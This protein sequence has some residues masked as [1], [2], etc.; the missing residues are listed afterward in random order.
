MEFTSFEMML[1]SA[2][3]QITEGEIIFSAFQWPTLAVYI[4]KQTHA[5]EACFMYESGIVENVLTPVVPSTLS[6]PMIPPYSV[7][8]GDSIDILCHLQ[9]NWA[10]K[11]LIMAA[12]IDRFGNVNTTVVGDYEKPKIRLPGGGG[13]PSIVALTKKTI[14]MLDEHSPRRFVKDIGFVTDFGYGSGR[15]DRFKKGFPLGTGPHAVISPLG[16][17]KFD[18]KTKEMYLDTVHPG[19]TVDEVKKNTS[20]DL[21]VSPSC[22]EAPPPT[23]EEI[24]ICRKVIREALDM[25]YNIRKEWY[26]QDE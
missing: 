10:D 17:L 2:A 12:M 4:A 24:R 16:I 22:K 13:A 15:D 25:R 21:M 19:V 8:C 11:C 26:V 18:E 3:R 9:S 7:Y 14:W 23:P 6:D 1:I 5:P 20:W